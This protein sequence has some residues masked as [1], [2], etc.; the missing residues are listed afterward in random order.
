MP[1]SRTPTR[2]LHGPAVGAASGFVPLVPRSPRPRAGPHPELDP[3]KSR[4]ARPVPRSR[5]RDPPPLP[6]AS[7]GSPAPHKLPTSHTLCRASCLCLIFASSLR[8]HFSEETSPHHPRNAWGPICLPQPL[9]PIKLA[10]TVSLCSSVTGR[11]S[12]NTGWVGGW[13]NG[14]VGEQM[15]GRRKGGRRGGRDG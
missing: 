12:V 4:H 13:M 11:C 10:W 2:H 1:P 5:P 7:S 14:W 15:D 8:D 9:S 6:A 3:E